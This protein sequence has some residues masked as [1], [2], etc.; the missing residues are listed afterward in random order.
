MTCHV[1]DALVTKTYTSLYAA[2][3]AFAVYLIIAAL[4]RTS[5]GRFFVYPARAKITE[6]YI[7]IRFLCLFRG[8]VLYNL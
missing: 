2:I 4:K 8:N 7:K 6:K 5:S 1:T 3:A